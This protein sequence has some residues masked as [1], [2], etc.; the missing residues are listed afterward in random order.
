MDSIHKYKPAADWNEIV[1]CAKQLS[2]EFNG[3]EE[4]EEEIGIEMEGLELEGELERKTPL[5]E[6][7]GA[8][9]ESKGEGEV[10]EEVEIEEDSRRQISNN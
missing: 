9:R 7:T 10:E 5:K 1:N 4:N 8:E 6:E 3:A 2:W